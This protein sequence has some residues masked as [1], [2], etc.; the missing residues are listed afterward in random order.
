MTAL[1]S[2]FAIPPSDPSM[3][4]ADT[5][6]FAALIAQ[7]QAVPGGTDNLPPFLAAL[8]AVLNSGGSDPA[9]MHSIGVMVLE[10]AAAWADGN[11]ADFASALRLDAQCLAAVRTALA[12]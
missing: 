9:R 5:A 7:L 2:A 10:A 1:S 8:L 3:T 6:T 11:D 12:I 4:P